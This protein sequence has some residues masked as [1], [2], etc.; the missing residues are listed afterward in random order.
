MDELIGLKSKDAFE[1]R[2]LQKRLLNL[3]G[4]I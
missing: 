3:Y 4:G 1:N 2:N